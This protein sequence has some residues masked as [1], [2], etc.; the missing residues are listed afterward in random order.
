M[1]KTRPDSVEAALA[2]I[3]DYAEK[4]RTT[5]TLSPSAAVNH[6]LAEDI[7][8]P[9][10]LPRFDS[11]AM[12][13]FAIRASDLRAAGNTVLTIAQIIAAGQS[14]NQEL[15]VGEAARIMTGAPVPP[16]SDRVIVQENAEIVGDQVR[17]GFVGQGKP[18]IRKAGEDIRQGSEILTAGT[19]LTTGHAMLLTA[20]GLDTVDVRAKPRVALLSTGDELVEGGDPLGAGK[21][22]DTNRPMLFQMLKDAGAEVTD[23]GIIPDD[24][25]AIVSALV[26]AAADHD[27]IVS[28]GGASA[29]FA[30]HLAQAVSQRGYL[31]FWKLDMRPGKPIGFGDVDHCPS[32][33]LP[34]NPV[35]A[36]V[37]FALFGRALLRGL[38]GHSQDI[39]QRLRLPIAKSHV[40]RQ[41]Q[42]QALMARFRQE[43]RGGITC[44]EPLPDQ[45]S[46]SF[47]SL[48]AAEALIILKPD[49]ILVEEGAIVEVVPLWSRFLPD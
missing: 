17:L 32:L 1:E 27:L 23:L 35:A 21:I 12:D 46:A 8:A 44:I 33:L 6:V 24:P 14:S 42:T 7:I 41:G 5:V 3:A 38:E 10:C 43:N 28:S 29:G 26:S 2:F 47:R 48:A 31:E 11:A 22:Y 25:L 30:D 19:R 13:G 37:G 4:I 20:L 16:G 34:G 45:G 18:H 9:V 39:Q 49:Q 40:K 15:G 36:A